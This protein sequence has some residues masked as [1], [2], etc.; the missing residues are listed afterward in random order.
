MKH[1]ALLLAIF[2]IGFGVGMGIK[3]LY[4]SKTFHPYTWDGNH[5]IILNCYGPE[6]SELQIIRAI[7]YWAIRGHNIGFYEHDPPPAVCL[8]SN[9]WGMIILRKAKRGSLPASTLAST[10]R[11]TTGF[12][13]RSVEIYY[14]PGSFNL[15]LINEHELGHAF[16]YSHVDIEGHIMHPLY[17]NMGKRFWIP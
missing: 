13:L 2:A 12:I 11:S 4:E 14:Q 16:G 8:Q 10:T 7:D 5:P 9:L 17:H 1:I 3:F 15:D 6:F